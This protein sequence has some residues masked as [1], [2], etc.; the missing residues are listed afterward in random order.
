MPSL[1]KLTIA[2]LRLEL[3]ERDLSS[4]GKKADLVERLKN[5]LKEEGHD[6]ETYVFEDKHAALISSITSLESK[7][8]SEISQ[9][10]TDITSL[11]SKVSSEISQVSTDITSLEN[12]VSTEITS[13]EKKVSSEISQVSSDVLKVST[14]IA[15]LEKKVSD[16][17][18]SSRKTLWRY[19]STTKVQ[20]RSRSQQAN[21]NLQEFEADVARVVRLAYPEVLDSI[22]EDIAVDNFVNGLKESEQQKALRLARPK[23]LYE[24]L[25][26]ALEHETASQ[27]S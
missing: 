11:E 19:P 4:T 8:S 21:E 27:T 18:N 10:S 25:A 13:L 15:S 2:D 22:L 5:A 20:L 6:P 17:V 7:V 24:A 23:V 14:D 9:V 1:C 16:F 3:E 12:K 26:T